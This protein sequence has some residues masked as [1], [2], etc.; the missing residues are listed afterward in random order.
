MIEDVGSLVSFNN[1][2]AHVDVDIIVFTYYSSIVKF[3]SE[4]IVIGPHKAM[5]D[6]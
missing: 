2:F 1:T 4:L 6:W 5:I 3:Y